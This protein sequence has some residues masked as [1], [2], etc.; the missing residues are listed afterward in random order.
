MGS[1]NVYEYEKIKPFLLDETH[2]GQ[3]GYRTVKNKINELIV[4]YNNIAKDFELYKKAHK[5]LELRVKELESGKIKL[6]PQKWDDENAN[7]E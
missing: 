4:G 3:P 6:Q 7:T 1:Q 5:S 2:H